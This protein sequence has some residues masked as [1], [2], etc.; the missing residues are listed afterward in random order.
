MLVKQAHDQ[1]PPYFILFSG[2]CPASVY[3]LFHI[4]INTCTMLVSGVSG[5]RPYYRLAWNPYR[6]TRASLAVV[7]THR[8]L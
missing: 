1:E 7:K 3:C 2:S 5:S 4:K 6:D 8:N